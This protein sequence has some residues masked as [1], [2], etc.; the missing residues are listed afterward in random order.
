MNL[1][2]YIVFLDNAS[3]DHDGEGLY[4]HQLQPSLKT[5]QA[6]SNVQHL[7]LGLRSYC[8]FHMGPLVEIVRKYLPQILTLT[9]NDTG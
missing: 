7:I 9:I 2:F 3:K 5:L 4:W 8:C 1:L 6:C